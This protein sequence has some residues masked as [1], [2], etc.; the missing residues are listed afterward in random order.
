MEQ[1]RLDEGVQFSAATCGAGNA[2]GVCIVT[3]LSQAMQVHTLLNSLL[4]SCFLQWES[5]LSN[6]EM[7]AGFKDGGAVK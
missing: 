6:D 3:S 2:G 4:E 1:A 5:K 7:R